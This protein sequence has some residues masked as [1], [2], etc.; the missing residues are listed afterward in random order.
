MST[1][2]KVE[3]LVKSFGKRR[4]INN[5]SMEVRSGEVMGFLGPNGSGKTTTIKMILGLLSVDSGAINIAGYDRNR[6]FEKALSCIGGIIENPDTY[7]YL[8]ARQN[9]RLYQRAHGEADSGRIEEVL[10]LVGLTARAGDKVRRYSLGMKQRLGLAQAILHH[11]K[12][13]ILDEP[14]NGLDPAGI[15]ELRDILK[16]LAHE[17]GI[18]VL[19]SSHL[20]SEMQL[21]CDRVC[22]IDKGAILAEKDIS[23][24]TEDNARGSYRLE[25]SPADRAARWLEEHLPDK[26]VHREGG[27]FDLALQKEELSEL[28]KNLVLAEISVVSVNTISRS[29]E[30]SFLEI[31]GGGNDIA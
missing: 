12:I 26:L 4:V 9:L 17:E 14:T 25:L 30:D 7:G 5:L 8:S 27:T 11:P 6:D 29:L 1:V 24:M 28:I 10:A 16:R 18:A 23:E 31:T 20:L 13:L 22:I 2:L 19:V 3:N 15:R 21:M